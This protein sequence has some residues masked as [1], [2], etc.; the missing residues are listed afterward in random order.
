MEASARR[1]GGVLQR[2]VRAASVAATGAVLLAA[3]VGLAGGAMAQ[4][5]EARARGERVATAAA[6]RATALPEER[7]CA[8]VESVARAAAPDAVRL[9]ERGVTRCGTPRG[10]EKFVARAPVGAG[11]VVE[12]GTSP[13]DPWGEASPLM[14]RLLVVLLVT[15]GVGV[16]A[17]WVVARDITADVGAVT[18]QAERMAR[19]E[20][21]ALDP[22]AVR[23]RDE[24]GALVAAFNRL[25]ERFEEEGALHR[26]ALGR[27]EAEEARKEAMVATLRHELRTPLNAVLGFADLLLSGVDG[28]LSPSQREDVDAIAQAGR[29][30]R[31]LVDDVFD[32]SAM[33]NGRFSLHPEG[34]DLA[35]VA[36]EVVREAEG[37]GRSRGVTLALDGPG[38][39][40]LRADPVA[41]RRALTNLVLNAVEHAGGH[42]RVA[43]APREGGGWT[44][45]V[46]DNGPGI[47][48]GELRRLFRPFERGRTAEARGAGLGLAITLGLVELHGGTLSAH[49]GAEGGSTFTVS[50][51]Q[52]EPA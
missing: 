22:V 38:E 36:R 47:P 28:E 6:A 50:L 51:P 39:A 8:A 34:C 19:G 7:R 29:H 46:Q 45:A 20:A 24:V 2:V 13:G 35:A 40:P 26:E 17:S 11:V 33:A 9:V 23:A 3:T 1:R 4:R 5:A 48:A 31:R 14:L 25:Q 37:V 27:L 16:A 30:R 32:L 49:A 52:G 12:V 10:G 21:R 41:L 44:V 18:A 42:V 43:L 15:G